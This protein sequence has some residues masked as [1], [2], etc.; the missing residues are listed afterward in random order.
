MELI[1]VLSHALSATMGTWTDEPNESSE[2]VSTETPT[3]KATSSGV[4]RLSL[5]DLKGQVIGSQDI[6][7]HVEL[8]VKRR[9]RDES[10]AKLRA[11]IHSLESNRQDLSEIT[12]SL[13]DAIEALQKEMSDKQATLRTHTNEIDHM[14]FKLKDLEDQLTNLEQ[15]EVDDDEKEV[16]VVTPRRRASLDSDD[17][18]GT[19]G[20]IESFAP[21]LSSAAKTAPTSP[22]TSPANASAPTSPTSDTVAATVVADAPAVTT[23]TPSSVKFSESPSPSKATDPAKA[24]ARV[25]MRKASERRINPGLT[26]SKSTNSKYCTPVRLPLYLPHLICLIM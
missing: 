14:D 4:K 19:D 9:E 7:K 17:S 3:A 20:T 15:E 16:T 22:A 12:D 24:S 1:G 13:N 2:E 8:K 10:K 11:E 6:N 25:M 5:E 18:L 21:S 23:T 26:T